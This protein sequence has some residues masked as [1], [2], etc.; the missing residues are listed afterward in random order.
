MAE[1][2]GDEQG[3]AEQRCDHPQQASDTSEVL[4][5]RFDYQVSAKNQQNS[6]E[7]HQDIRNESH[8]HLLRRLTSAQL[9]HAVDRCGIGEADFC[10]CSRNVRPEAFWPCT[11]SVR[12]SGERFQQAWPHF[13][14]GLVK[15]CPRHQ[16][17][18]AI[19]PGG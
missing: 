14:G 11:I 3:G 7:K 6:A 12:D 10:I 9:C 19:F 8:L 18:L 4:T 13:G 17:R 15:Q 1:E 16:A 2:A 5:R